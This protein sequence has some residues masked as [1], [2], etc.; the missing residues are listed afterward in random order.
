MGK[1]AVAIALTAA[2]RPNWRG[3]RT[4]GESCGD[5]RGGRGLCW[6]LPRARKTR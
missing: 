4:A 6:Q 5:W 2:E 1:P 3:W